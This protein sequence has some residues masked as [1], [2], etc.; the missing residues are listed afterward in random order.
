MFGCNIRVCFMLQL[1]CQ[2]A[3][4]K[5]KQGGIVFGMIFNFYISLLWLGSHD[6]DISSN[7]VHCYRLTKNISNLPGT[8]KNVLQ[9]P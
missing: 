8:K 1:H 6:V 2:V 4:L 5:I 9:E 3:Q 7:M